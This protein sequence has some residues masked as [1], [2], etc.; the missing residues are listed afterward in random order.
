MRAVMAKNV[1]T[2]SLELV[3]R[4]FRRDEK[5]VADEIAQMLEASGVEFSLL[6]REDGDI[7]RIRVG[8]RSK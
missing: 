2:G 7:T 3:L 4:S 5:L 6:R 8:V 1:E